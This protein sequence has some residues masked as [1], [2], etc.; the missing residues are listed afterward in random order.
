MPEIA[1]ED[2]RDQHPA[3]QLDGERVSSSSRPLSSPEARRE[4][5]HDQRREHE[6]ERREDERREAMRLS[7]LEARRHAG[8]LAQPQLHAAEGRDEGGG[9][10]RAREH[11]EDE[12]GQAERDPVGGQLGVG[13]EGV[14]DGDLS[15]A[16]RGNASR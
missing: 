12:V 2:R 7:T 8:L 6:G 15:A 13:A 5:R 1:E 4:Q 16:A 14:G 10:R 11:L 9:E 3:R